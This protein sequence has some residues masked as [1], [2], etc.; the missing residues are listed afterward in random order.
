MIKKRSVATIIR[1]I[2]P[3]ATQAAAPA[4]R[5]K[6]E[7]RITLR[8]FGQRTKFRQAGICSIPL[9]MREIA[10]GCISSVRRQIVQVGDPRR[11]GPSILR[12]HPTGIILIAIGLSLCPLGGGHLT[13][14]AAPSSESGIEEYARGQVA[15]REYQAIQAQD[16]RRL[17]HVDE[18]VSPAE[19]LG[20]LQVALAC[21]QNA[22]ARGT[23]EAQYQLL[24]WLEGDGIAT[25]AVPHRSEFH[26]C[27]LSRWMEARK[28]Q[29]QSSHRFSLP[30]VECA[31]L[32][33]L[34]TRVRQEYTSGFDLSPTGMQ[35][36]ALERLQAQ[37]FRLGTSFLQMS[38]PPYGQQGGHALAR[39]VPPPPVSARSELT[40]CPPPAALKSSARAA[41]YYAELGARTCEL[42]DETAQ[43]C[44][45]PQG[46]FANLLSQDPSP[47]ARHH[48]SRGW[49]G[50][51][52]GEGQSF[53][54]SVFAARAQ[55]ARLGQ[56]DHR[57]E[58]LLEIGLLAGDPDCS[59]LAFVIQHGLYSN[60][61]NRSRL[62][63]I[64]A[65]NK[66][67]PRP[68]DPERGVLG[69]WIQAWL[70]LKTVLSKP[71]AMPSGKLTDLLEIANEVGQA[72]REGSADALATLLGW[73]QESR[74]VPDELVKKLWEQ[75]LR[76]PLSSRSFYW[77]HPGATPLTLAETLR[78]SL[79]P[80]VEPLLASREVIPWREKIRHQLRQ[81]VELLELESHSPA[82]QN[83]EFVLRERE[84][85]TSTTDGLVASWYSTSPTPPL[86]SD[87]VTFVMAEHGWPRLWE[88]IRQPHARVVVIAICSQN[89]LV[90]GWV[91]IGADVVILRQLRWGRTPLLPSD[92]SR[93][94]A[95]RLAAFALST[96]WN[97]ESFALM[98]DSVLGFEGLPDH[99]QPSWSRITRLTLRRLRDQGI[100]AV[101]IRDRLNLGQTIKAQQLTPPMN[102]LLPAD[103]SLHVWAA[104]VLFVHHALIRTIFGASAQ[105]LFPPKVGS[106][107][108][109]IYLQYRLAQCGLP[110]WHWGSQEL[111]VL[112]RYPLVAPRSSQRF[113]PP[114]IKPYEQGSTRW[115]VAPLE[116][117]QPIPLSLSV[118]LETDLM[119][120]ELSNPPAAMDL[121]EHTASP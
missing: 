85:Y 16:I 96:H 71:P 28:A 61:F 4:S 8:G 29:A 84:I 18:P 95:R 53:G 77:V 45:D 10:W 24:S 23:P 59:A 79:L 52:P 97:L 88:S 81:F 30:E 83:Q 111:R 58:D 68:F 119:P 118:V 70:D 32:N 66:L 80:L 6:Y 36:K 54:L 12:F 89:S 102:T 87:Q 64:L 63:K 56:S 50:L 44:L 20:Q 55:A 86:A 48:E 116:S 5:V 117:T 33:K 99:G 67:C 94:A 34:I 75:A 98:D 62:G 92:L 51:P 19:A 93:I 42:L 120:R 9:P 1:S 41:A 38:Q 47:E 100:A 22:C 104:P 91:G 105:S 31:F 60:P 21:T 110:V 2:T 25:Q 49:Q 40:N 46:P 14:L 121:D 3:Y 43:F 73:A 37:T 57:C 26:L 39:S 103:Q 35:L 113:H 101:G 27:L 82:T 15:W 7:S 112:Q 13:V 90:R 17:D 78:Q 115:A 109:E 11:S 106:P 76:K 69:R 114:L 107:H 65:A 74:L 108:D 72:A